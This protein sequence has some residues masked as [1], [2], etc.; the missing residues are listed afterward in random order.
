L[1]ALKRAET[2]NPDHY[3]AA[4]L[5]LAE[6][7]ALVRMGQQPAAMASTPNLVPGDWLGRVAGMNQAL[8]GVMTIAAAPLGALALAFLPIEGA[9]LIDV[10]TALLGIVPLLVFRVPQPRSREYAAPAPVLHAI[11]DGA[12]Y[13]EPRYVTDVITDHAL[14][15][16][17]ERAFERLGGSDLIHVDIRVVAATK[18]DLGDIVSKGGFRE[19]LF[20]RLNVLHIDLPPL[21]DRDEDIVLLA[22]YLLKRYAEEFGTKVKGFTPN[23]GI[24]L[25]KHSWP[26][27]VRELENRIKKA[28]IL[29]EGSMVG[30][31]DLDLGEA[32]TQSANTAVSDSRPTAW[33]RVCWSRQIRGPNEH[34]SSR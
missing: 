24:A 14:R 8:Q 30:P 18:R 5:Q 26:G 19:D 28:V 15:F 9:L 31:R 10:A 1:V 13:S 4:R 11:R 32:G 12:V 21:S 23:A 6:A 34:C 3:A 20:Y 2:M 22:R 17:E 25:R 27:N 7:R 16:L 33:I 29:C